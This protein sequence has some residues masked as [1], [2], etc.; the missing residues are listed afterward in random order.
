M[1]LV[2]KCVFVF[3]CL[4]M[5]LYACLLCKCVSRR[6]FV[7]V[8]V[9]VDFWVFFV[10]VSDG[11]YVC[12][13]VCISEYFYAYMHVSVYAYLCI[14]MHVCVCLSMYMCMYF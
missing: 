9:Y 6:M 13:Y 5:S 7:W 3:V 8:F 14:Y 2:I 10:C 12:V 4:Y 11:F 1:Y